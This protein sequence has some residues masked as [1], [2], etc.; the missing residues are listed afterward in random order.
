MSDADFYYWT[1]IVLFAI[2]LGFAGSGLSI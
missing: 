2:S 1:T